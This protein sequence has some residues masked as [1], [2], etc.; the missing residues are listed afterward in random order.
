MA[1]EKKPSAGSTPPLQERD[2]SLF[3]IDKI[4]SGTTGSL[5][6]KIIMGLLIVVFAVGF[7]FMDPSLFGGFGGG[8]GNGGGPQI[9]LNAT[10]ASLGDQS[11]TRGQFLQAEQY[12]EQMM[13]QYGMTIGPNEKLAMGYRTL[14]SLAGNLALIAA[15]KNEGIQV[16]DKDVDD[17]IKS[18][19]EEE[20]KQ[21]QDQN[22]AGFRRQVEARFGSIQGYKDELVKQMQAGREDIKNGL[23]VE[24]LQKKI[25][26]GAESTEDLFKRSHTK[27]HVRQLVVDLPA[28]PP[29]SKD[30]K[31]AQEQAEATA[32]A[33]MDKV[34]QQAKANPTADN[35]VKLVKQYSGDQ[36]TK[37]KGGDLG[38][39]IPQEIPVDYP[40]RDALMKADGK[41]V[42]PLQDS[43]TKAYFLFYIEGRQLDLPKDYAK[44]KEQY[45]KE[46]KDSRGNQAWSSYQQKVTADAQQQLQVEDPALQAFALQNEKIP[47]VS[48]AAA[49][50]LRQQAVD[51]YQQ[52]LKNAVGDEAAAI[53]LQ[54]AS[55]YTSLKQPQ[56]AVEVLAVAAKESPEEPQVLLSYA[57]ALRENKKNDEALKQ[58]K[59][60]SQLLDNRPSTPSMFGSNPNDALRFQIASEYETLG[61]KDLADAERKKIKPQQS[62]VMGN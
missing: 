47:S 44:K 16:T 26:D 13:S 27:L 45:L 51:L 36:Q 48:G 8:G 20:I 18:N 40:M 15:A 50:K 57:T 30:I 22:P 11:I 54:L 1:K 55:L 60:V 31:T 62:P 53:R 7:L 28:V 6:T 12:Q 39:K 9:N 14:Q 52:G 61:K 5:M 23:M 3:S 49:D 2:A 17:K 58:L 32:K 19:I 25:Q 56:K 43:T 10:V 41:I 34:A 37:A 46:A 29:N 42:G 59:A 35:F 38:W 24:K 21:Q 33:E 4:R